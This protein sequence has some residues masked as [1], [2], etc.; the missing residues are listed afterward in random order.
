MDNV[1]TTNGCF[2]KG[3]EFWQNRVKTRNGAYEDGLVR[4]N[5]L[6]MGSVCRNSAAVSEM[7]WNSRRGVFTHRRKRFNM[8]KYVKNE[9]GIRNCF[10]LFSSNMY[11]RN[12]K[13]AIRVLCVT[14]KLCLHNNFLLLLS[15]HNQFIRASSIFILYLFKNNAVK[16]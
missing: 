3:L 16:I 15:S 6:V 10:V 4:I 2:L 13:R 8:E 9:I 5:T 1:W 7:H 11:E 14:F 12:W